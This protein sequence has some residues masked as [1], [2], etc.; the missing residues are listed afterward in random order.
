MS[1]PVRRLRLRVGSFLGAVAAVSLV[2]VSTT[3]FASRW[4]QAELADAAR[5]AATHGV[6]LRWREADVDWRLRAVILDLQLDVPAGPLLERPLR[7]LCQHVTVAPDLVGGLRGS[8]RASEV[9][10]TCTGNHVV[11]AWPARRQTS[12][13]SIERPTT[14][15]AR[16]LQGWLQRIDRINL[17]SVSA[18]VSVDARVGPVA[19]TAT[20]ELSASGSVDIGGSEA[21]L[22]I[23]ALGATGKLVLHLSG[24]RLEGAVFRTNDPTQPA[25]ELQTPYGPGRLSVA[26]LAASAQRWTAD[27][28][29]IR[30]ELRP[31]AG[32]D[33]VVY[34]ARVDATLG[35]HLS[36]VIDGLTADHCEGVAGIVAASGELPQWAATTQRVSIGTASLH[37]AADGTQVT[38]RAAA[39]S[40]RWG[41]VAVR[42]VTVTAPALAAVLRPSDWTRIVA[43][44]PSLDVSHASDFFVRQPG[45]ANLFR[46][47]HSL[48]SPL[49]A[50]PTADDDEEGDAVSVPEQP[51]PEPAAGAGRRPAYSWM[52]S[53]ARAHFQVFEAH[54]QM[55]RAWPQRWLPERTSVHV[56]SG[57][58]SRLDATGRADSGLRDIALDIDPA[59]RTGGA[60]LQGGGV[61]FDSRGT[62][63]RIGVQWRRDPTSLHHNIELRV[64]GAGFAQVVAA[65]IPGMTLGDAADVS[66]TARV[67]VPGPDRIAIE[68]H[69][70]AHRMGIR[71]WRLADRPI[72]D[73]GLDATFHADLDKLGAR[74]TLLSPDVRVFTPQSDLGARFQVAVD[75]AHVSTQP[76][77]ALRIT[78]PM[79]D[80]GALLHAVPGSLTPTLGRVDA[81]GVLGGH[82]GVTV[83]LPRTGAVDVDLALADTPCVVDRLGTIDL[84]ALAGE[85]SWPVNEN[86]KE[87]G[88]VRWGPTSG[89]WTPLA[90]IPNWVSYGMWATED[91]FLRHRGLSEDLI[92]KALGIDLTTGRFTYGGSTITQQLVKTVFLRRTKALARKFEEM[93]IVWQIE[94]RLGKRRIL[95]LYCNGVE[96]GPQVYGITRAAWAFYQ[97]TPGQLTPE[98]GLYLAIIKPSP[99]SGYWTMRGNGWGVWYQSKMQKY[100]DKFLR[101]GIITR[102]QYERAEVRAFKP[103][104]NPPPKAGDRRP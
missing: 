82:A 79:Q 69:A 14:R 65:R 39:V 51:A 28:I 70:F 52:A 8:R 1:A 54:R 47:L 46:G 26:A 31:R 64:T 90:A 19:L 23:A 10:L 88:E 55:E 12:S 9:A 25:V 76:R 43:A 102:D 33:P 50:T 81:H 56:R 83:T 92:E 18:R 53:L 61:P 97:K 7:W 93:L 85:F 80:C 44:E 49:H 2:W 20:T 66:L 100:M 30:G 37:R 71:W 84:D 34:A 77:V 58:V 78:A 48:R 98:E 87:L 15:G 91:P 75:V 36:V 95:E 57:R 68:G 72:D 99:R 89:S 73:F 35:G 103:Q 32:H 21:T 13:T 38:V 24:R 86:G 74:W 22:A 16:Q 11:A 67:V 60:A 3:H 29:R 104:F 27:E 42:E 41:A 96:F 63:G 45:L 101:E 94:R 62:W 4:L 59:V 5:T 17:E 40:G 6:R